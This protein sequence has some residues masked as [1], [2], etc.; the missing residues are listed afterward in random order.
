MKLIKLE[1]VISLTTIRRRKIFRTFL[2]CIAL[3]L[4]RWTKKFQ[5]LGK[6]PPNWEDCLN[7]FMEQSKKSFCETCFVKLFVFEWQRNNVGEAMPSEI[8]KIKNFKWVLPPI[9]LHLAEKR[10]RK[11]NMNQYFTWEPCMCVKI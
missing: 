1:D 10:A 5:N 2:F 6:G 9:I 11:I 8:A 7:K 4:A 3:H